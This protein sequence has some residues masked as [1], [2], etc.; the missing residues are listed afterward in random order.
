[1]L[2]IAGFCQE[3]GLGRVMFLP[4]P[5]LALPAIASLEPGKKVLVEAEGG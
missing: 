1:M 5:A 2:Y 3:A 4:H